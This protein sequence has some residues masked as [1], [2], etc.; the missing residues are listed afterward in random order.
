MKLMI[1]T[2]KKTKFEANNLSPSARQSFSDGGWSQILERLTPLLILA[3]T[4][5]WLWK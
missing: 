3:T 1:I 5:I 2:D 4:F